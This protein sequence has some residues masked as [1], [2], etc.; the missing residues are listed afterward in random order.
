MSIYF[1]LFVFFQSQA[2]NLGL[3]CARQAFYYW[4]TPLA[5]NKCIEM[6]ETLSSLRDEHHEVRDGTGVFPWLTPTTLDH[7]L[8]WGKPQE[9]LVLQTRF[10]LCLGI[11]GRK[12]ETQRQ[13]TRAPL[14]PPLLSWP[15]P[16]CSVSNLSSSLS[17]LLLLSMNF[18]TLLICYLHLLLCVIVCVC[19][20][21]RTATESQFFLSPHG[22]WRSN[23]G[24]QAWNPEPFPDPKN[25]FQVSHIDIKMSM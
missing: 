24:R 23:W 16:H 11:V 22:S 2:L 1:F 19:G 12:R 18:K 4:V 6:L 25:S 13:G 20:G 14:L 5:P 17:G 3:E 7:S 9:S 10:E 8:Q 21:Q 15:E